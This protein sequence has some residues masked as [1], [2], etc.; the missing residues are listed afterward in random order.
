MAGTTVVKA[1]AEAHL[2][3]LEHAP[4]P[5]PYLPAASTPPSC[6]GKRS[7]ARD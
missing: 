4:D 7:P 1:V 5:G 3:D 2:H 6:T